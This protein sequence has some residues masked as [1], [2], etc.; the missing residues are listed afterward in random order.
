ME[1]PSI[2]H[3]GLWPTASQSQGGGQV[4]GQG[5][6][7]FGHIS[8]VSRME[9]AGFGFHVV[10]LVSKSEKAITCGDKTG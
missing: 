5:P 6:T 8:Q 4:I 9:R 3:C 10:S 7:E 1:P 2:P